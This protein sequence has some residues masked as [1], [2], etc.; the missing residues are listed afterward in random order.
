[1]EAAFGR[2]WPGADEVCHRETRAG[3]GPMGEG[4][5]RGQERRDLLHPAAERELRI[6]VPYYGAESHRLLRGVGERAYSD[7]DCSR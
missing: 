5:R 1:M 4:G 3:D 7:Q 2:R 6:H